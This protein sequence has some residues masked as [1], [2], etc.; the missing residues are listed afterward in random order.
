MRLTQMFEEIKQQW[1]KEILIG[2]CILWDD[3]EGLN[4]EWLD[5]LF[6]EIDTSC[7]HGEWGKL[8]N[9]GIV[10]GLDKYIRSLQPP[11]PEKIN[12]ECLD[13]N[14]AVEAIKDSLAT[15]DSG[16]YPE[17]YKYENDLDTLLINQEGELNS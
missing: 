10:C 11:Y 1:P 12:I 2:D 6:W 14:R 9:W 16:Y 7:V 8:M 3:Q 15:P 5:S 17:G 13:I 4:C